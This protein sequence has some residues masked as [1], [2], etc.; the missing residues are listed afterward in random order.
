ML[1][2]VCMMGRLVADPELKHTPSDIPVVSFRIAV[3]RTYVKAGAE[4][5]ADFFNVVAWRSTAEFISKF[6][7]KGNLI[8]VEGNLQ[9]RQYEKDGIKRTVYEI[10]A[11]QAHFTG[12]KR[13]NANPSNDSDAHLSDP[14]AGY[15]AP[16]SYSNADSTDFQEISTDDDLPF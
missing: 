8:A 4:R 12:E 5:E 9:S 1:N 6:F 10:V 15:R 7:S 2:Y 11:N 16:A 14:P 3:D 13:L